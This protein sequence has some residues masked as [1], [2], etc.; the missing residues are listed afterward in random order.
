MKVTMVMTVNSRK[1]I[2]NMWGS[3]ARSKGLAAPMHVA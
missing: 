3:Q 1:T 2:A